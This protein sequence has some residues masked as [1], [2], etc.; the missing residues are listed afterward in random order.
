MY[1]YFNEGLALPGEIDALRDEVEDL[2]LVLLILDP[3]FL[4]APDIVWKEEEAGRVFARLKS[5]ICD[6]YDCTVL[7]SDHTSWASQEAGANVHGYGSVMKA[8]VDRF[9]LFTSKS[10]G[11]LFVEA[12]GNDIAGLERTRV[13][14]DPNTWELV[15]ATREEEIM[16]HI[17]AHLRANPSA[18]K[19][20]TAEA[21][22]YR[23]EDVL[24][25]YDRAREEL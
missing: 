19:T 4:V 21:I 15:P 23:K 13:C 16:L 12:R 5:E 8:A 9:G 25:L 22:P 18:K 2:G 1:V 24:E 7:I 11:A 6:P 10:R 3:F 20:A 17:K 14:L